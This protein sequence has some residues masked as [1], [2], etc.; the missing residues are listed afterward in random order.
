MVAAV[1]AVDKSERVRERARTRLMS[2]SV[3]LERRPRARARLCI[4]LF[5][6]ARRCLR[7]SPSFL[8]FAFFCRSHCFYFLL[9]EQRALALVSYHERAG[10]R[11]CG[12]CVFAIRQRGGVFI[13]LVR[14]LHHRF[15]ANLIRDCDGGG[16]GCG[17]GGIEFARLHLRLFSRFFL[18]FL[19]MIAACVRS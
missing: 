13:F 14:F 5:F 4:F 18:S 2:A 1:A 11:A 9:S 6:V 19:V 17:G 8:A 3:A 10:A 7:F 16:G 15:A 12:A